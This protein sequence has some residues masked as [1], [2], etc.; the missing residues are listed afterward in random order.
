MDISEGL[1]NMNKLVTRKQMKG[2]G[3]LGSMC[4][5]SAPYYSDGGGGFYNDAQG[6]CE[7]PGG[8]PAGGGVIIPTDS[9]GWWNWDAFLKALQIA[10]S[11]AVQVVKADNQGY[12]TPNGMYNPYGT[13]MYS[14][15]TPQMAQQAALS[16]QGGGTIGISSTT[17]MMVAV[18]G[19]ALVMLMRRG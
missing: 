2:I 9:S 11:T 7:A 5:P 3:N 1:V 13:G 6:S 12:Y 10:G 16:Y 18:A 15:M 14:G 8:M 19:I 17:L 4:D